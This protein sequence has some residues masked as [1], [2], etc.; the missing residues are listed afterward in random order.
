[1]TLIVSD[2]EGNE[3]V[4]QTNY[5]D[6]A[7]MQEYIEN[8]PEAIPLYQINNELEIS[9]A[10]REFSVETGFLDALAFDQNGGVYILETKLDSNTTKRE[11]I[12]QAFDYGAALW[13]NQHPNQFINNLD[14]AIKNYDSFQEWAESELELEEDEYEEFKENVFENLEDGNFSYAIV[15]DEIK[16]KLKTR[17]RYLMANSMFDLYGVELEYYQHDGNTIVVPNLVGTEVKKNTQ[18]TKKSSERRYPDRGRVFDEIQKKFDELIEDEADYTRG[19]RYRQVRFSN[20]PNHHHLEWY[21]GTEDGEKYLQM[22]MDFEKKNDSDHNE[23]LLE[24]FQENRFT[25]IKEKLDIDS[26]FTKESGVHAKFYI[27][28]DATIEQ[29]KESNELQEW[30]A[31]KTA[32]LYRL[33][34]DDLQEKAE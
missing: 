3:I 31:Q 1:M 16:E 17:I 21:F 23:E 30:A 25:E 14:A 6:E 18:S 33:V 4:G 29:F 9:I 34:K 27:K 13:E 12:A 28:K 26:I 7:E 15:M 11:V 22:R 8:N 10:A 24:Y 5:E 2:E 19:N 20:V 32:E